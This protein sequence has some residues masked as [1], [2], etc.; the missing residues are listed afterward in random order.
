MLQR[1]QDAMGLTRPELFILYSYVKLDIKQKLVTFDY[2]KHPFI[3]DLIVR[4][5][6]S[7]LAAQYKD[8]LKTHPLKAEILSTL[9]ANIILDELGISY[10]YRLVAETKASVGDIMI[11]TFKVRDLYNIEELLDRLDMLTS[12]P[13]NLVQQSISDACRLVRRA[14]RWVHYHLKTTIDMQQWHR[15]I[16]DLERVYPDVLRG[17]SLHTYNKKIDQLTKKKVP[18]NLARQIASLPF[19][20]SALDLISLSQRTSISTRDLASLYFIIGER[21]HLEEMREDLASMDVTNY[22]EALSRSALRD[23]I[24]RYHIEILSSI[25]ED[26]DDI[27]DS[28]TFFENWLVQQDESLKKWDNLVEQISLD[29]HKSQ[30]FLLY[31]VSIRE[32]KAFLPSKY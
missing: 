25:V 15:E 4:E 27:D 6:P 29:S 24:D 13:H 26:T 1:S 28:D 3:E 11:Y 22:W 17:Q 2:S 19:A 16:T 31:S 9:V 8:Q 23:D 14:T 10:I 12:V 7:K 20:V 5:F 30:D 21:L 32:L 18:A